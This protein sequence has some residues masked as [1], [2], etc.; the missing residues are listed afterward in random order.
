M[1]ITLQYNKTKK[2]GSDVK[3]DQQLIIAG[4]QLLVFV[5][6]IIMLIALFA[7]KKKAKTK[8]E[9]QQLDEII[10]SVIPATVST[11]KTLC[12]QTGVSYSSKVAAKLAKKEIKKEN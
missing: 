11:L 4:I 10:A 8:E 2:E 9:Q 6:N 3:I 12:E 7:K 1:Y 5:L